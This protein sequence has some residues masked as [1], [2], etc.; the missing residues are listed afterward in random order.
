MQEHIQVFHAQLKVVSLFSQ[1]KV[2]LGFHRDVFTFLG[3]HR[4]VFTFLGFHRDV[5][6]LFH[7]SS[8][9]SYCPELSSRDILV[10]H[11]FVD[12]IQQNMIHKV[13]AGILVECILHKVHITIFSFR[14]SISWF[15]T[16]LHNY[17]C[18]IN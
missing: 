14:A 18:I 7:I 4:D 6:T 15:I 17:S 16:I 1:A 9:Y 2:V 5:F 3:F 11:Q 13:H 12:Y 10:S 8:R